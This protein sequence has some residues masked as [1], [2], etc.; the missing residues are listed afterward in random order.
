MLTLK[1]NTKVQ[2]VGGTLEEHVAERGANSATL[3]DND[4]ATGLRHRL[5]A[6]RKEG[7]CG[8]RGRDECNE[9]VCVGRRCETTGGENDGGKAEAVSYA[10]TP[11]VF[12]LCIYETVHSES[13]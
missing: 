5:I 7:V 3:N 11:A 10:S 4:M 13:Q 6:R 1:K 9:T 12:F 2:R 8:G